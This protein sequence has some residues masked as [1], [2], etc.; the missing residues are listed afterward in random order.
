MN[1]HPKQHSVTIY[2]TSSCP[3][4]VFAKDFFKNMQV[5]FTDLNVGSDKRAAQEMVQKSGQMGVPVVD[6]DGHIIVG[7]QPDEFERLL[8]L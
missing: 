1:T 7:Y 8:S 2:S 4:C 6:I 3:F 5:P